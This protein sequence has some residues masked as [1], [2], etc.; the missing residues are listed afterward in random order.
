RA[1]EN[2]QRF[3]EERDAKQVLAEVSLRD[4]L[5]G[6]GNRRHAMHLLEALHP[7]DALVMIDLDNFK[8]VNDTHG[9]G[10]GDEVL[11]RLVDHLRKQV[12]HPEHI[13]RYGGEEFLL[14]LPG[15]G[16]NAGAVARRLV[17]SWR[18][19]GPMA[20]FSAGVAVHTAGAAPTVTLAKADAA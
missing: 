1:L 5:T 8:E 14:V 9:H 19:L 15:V 18:E 12:R 7:R 11:V 6:V 20:T 17:E 10:T 2:A 16:D 13:A 4:E 3:G